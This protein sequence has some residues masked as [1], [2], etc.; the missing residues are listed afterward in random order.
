[1]TQRKARHIVIGPGESPRGVS[2]ERTEALPYRW[3]V[4]VEDD[5]DGSYSATFNY[6]AAAKHY[7]L[8]L[9]LLLG[10]VELFGITS[11]QQALKETK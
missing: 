4:R 3:E 10:P 1:M 8:S 11:I 9:A 2:I 5:A 7:A 6:W